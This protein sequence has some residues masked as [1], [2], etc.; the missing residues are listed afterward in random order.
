MMRASLSPS[1]SANSIKVLESITSTHLP[2]IPIPRSPFPDANDAKRIPKKIKSITATMDTTL[3]EHSRAISS[4]NAPKA[5]SSHLNVQIHP[6]LN[7]LP[8]RQRRLPPSPLHLTHPKEQYPAS[9][10]L[11]P[12]PTRSPAPLQI[13]PENPPPLV[14][15]P[16]KPLSR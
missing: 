7:P 10:P 3:P 1:I 2:M 11:P 15:A 6:A 5:S 14:A 9:H 12:I 8:S 13:S 4:V 16:L